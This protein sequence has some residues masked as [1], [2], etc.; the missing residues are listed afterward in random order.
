MKIKVVMSDGVLH[1]VALGWLMVSE[2][3]RAARKA[4]VTFEAN[5]EF[6][7]EHFLA[8]GAMFEGGWTATHAA[9]SLRRHASRRMQA[10]TPSIGPVA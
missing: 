5:R 7:D 1:T 3:G 2:F 8:T 4:Q 6:Y 10:Q 9:T